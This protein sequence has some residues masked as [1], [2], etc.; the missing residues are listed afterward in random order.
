MLYASCWTIIDIYFTMH[1][2]S[3]IKKNQC[4]VIVN[5]L[6]SFHVFYNEHRKGNCAASETIRYSLLDCRRQVTM[7][8]K[9]LRPAI[10]TEFSGSKGDGRRKFS[11]L[12][13]MPVSLPSFSLFRHASE[14][15]LPFII[16]QN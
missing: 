11:D 4:S 13:R 3:S 16:H 12:E 8:R 10:L 9:T 6:C 2:T 1:G 7:T 14:T 15:V 5:A